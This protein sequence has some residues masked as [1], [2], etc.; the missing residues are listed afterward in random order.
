LPVAHQR[1]DAA[2]A[3]FVTGQ[4]MFGAVIEAEKSLRSLEL[5][6]QMAHAAYATRRAELERALGRIPGLDSGEVRP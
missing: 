4:N 6:Y 2:R 5:E 1:I 3:G